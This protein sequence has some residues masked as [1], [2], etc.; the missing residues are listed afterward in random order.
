MPTSDRR[1]EANR[2]NARLSTGPTTEAGKEASK[3]N[4]LTHGLAGSGA[5]LTDDLREQYQIELFAF[6]GELQ[7]RKGLE[8]RL[9]E[10]AAIASARR[11]H[12][13]AAQQDHLARRRL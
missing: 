5:C 7:P 4:R 3:R 2:Q 9:V 1:T 11:V 13:S 6:H 8:E 10:E 12:A